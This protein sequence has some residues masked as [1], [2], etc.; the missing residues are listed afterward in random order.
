MSKQKINIQGT[1]IIIFQK[2]NEDYISL[3]DIARN[4]TQMSQK[5]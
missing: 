2:N 1:E 5:T 4:K 3:T